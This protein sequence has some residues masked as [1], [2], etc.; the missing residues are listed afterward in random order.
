ME[1]PTWGH[2]VAAAASSAELAAAVRRER[3]RLAE[4]LHDD[5]L[6]RVM[7][8]QQDLIEAEEEDDAGLRADVR[9]QLSELA[10]SL[11][12]TTHAMHDRSL[13]ELP[14]SRALERIAT[15]AARRGRLAVTT[16]VAPE[17]AR[18]HDGLITGLVR[19]LLANVARHA[20]AAN[21]E[22]T[23]AR[24]GEAIMLRVRDDGRGIGEGELERAARSG[25]IGHARLRRTLSA[26][27]GTI[28]IVS[29]PGA[30]TTVACT[31]PVAALRAQQHLERSLEEG[32]RTGLRLAGAITSPPEPSAEA[33][34]VV[35]RVTALCERLDEASGEARLDRLLGEIAH[36]VGA[37]L[38]WTVVICVGRPGEDTLVARAAHGLDARSW[39]MARAVAFTREQWEPMLAARFDRGGAYLIPNGA[40][41]PTLAPEGSVDPG[42][43]RDGDDLLVPFHAADGR[44]LGVISLEAPV[45]GRRPTD[46]AL[47]AMVAV[48]ER[49]GGLVR[50]AH[51]AAAGARH[52]HALAG[53]L[54]ATAEL[55]AELDPDAIPRRVADAVEGHLGFGRV[56]V[57]A[58]GADG[59]LRPVAARGEV[60][61]GLEP[62]SGAELASLDTGEQLLLE[63][64][65][66][67]SALPAARRLLQRPGVGTRDPEAWDGHLL[68]VP[69]RTSDG[70]V[71]GLIWLDEPDDGL[72]PSRRTVK[73]LGSFADHV[74]AALAGARIRAR[75][76]LQ[77][78][79][80]ELTRLPDR[81][82]FSEELGREVARAAR[83]G[84]ASM[85][86][87]AVVEG[88]PAL[89]GPAA[90]DRPAAL[91]GLQ[92]VIGAFRAELRLEDRAFRIDGGLFALL[93]VGTE[94]PPDTK[95][96][97]LRIAAR[98]G[99]IGRGHGVAVHFGT[100]VIG[101]QACGPADVLGRAR[102]Q[103]LDG[104]RAR[105]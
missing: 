23:V 25:H 86:V 4:A 74:G 13:E 37:G 48:A 7:L 101:V 76:S 3:E 72:L 41:R 71:V 30:G 35:A 73:A 103:L 54:Q 75:L 5:A 44:L 100:A 6:Q 55:T 104:R 18:V 97:T 95:A 91:E 77:S 52:T 94:R 64:G 17:A 98:L 81:R 1:E 63:P 24:E 31:L 29:A 47:E 21:V 80:D 43:W 16:V 12:A 61:D 39:A 84:L 69:V 40:L 15:D 83:T 92:E 89:D 60:S 34:T 93:L 99:S 56:I 8:A 33:R 79:P 28:E 62:L 27:D 46:E 9:R 51:E 82:A 45:G 105:T 32:G 19:E 2:T 102:R 59:L 38:G 22:V 10:H 20:K 78:G 88:C 85:L 50:R 57:E 87:L 96:V 11:R 70:D 58:V 68:M 14:L 26:V 42:A 67:E 65:R 53:L 90:R 49:T 36:V 66:A